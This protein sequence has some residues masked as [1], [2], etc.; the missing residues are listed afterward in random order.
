M[1]GNYSN[2]IRAACTVMEFQNIVL[3]IQIEC[4]L[5]LSNVLHYDYR[6][7][8]VLHYDYLVLA[9]IHYDYLDMLVLPC[10]FDIVFGK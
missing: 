8:P 2:C 7:L 5:K 3:H 9:V 6:V 10:K 1:L 4:I